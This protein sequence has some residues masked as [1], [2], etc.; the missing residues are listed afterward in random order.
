L[1]RRFRY[2]AGLLGTARHEVLPPAGYCPPGTESENEVGF[3]SIGRASSRPRCESRRAEARPPTPL[4]KPGLDPCHGVRRRP[5][6]PT[7]RASYTTWTFG[8]ARRFRRVGTY[9]AGFAATVPSD[10][11]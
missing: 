11:V 5:T 4:G 3:V 10:S 6:T 7:G 2:R 9:F 1:S 8:P